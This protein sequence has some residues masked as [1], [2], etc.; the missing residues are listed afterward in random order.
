VTAD[1]NTKPKALMIEG[2]QLYAEALDAARRLSPETDPIPLVAMILTYA[3]AAAI[4]ASIRSSSPAAVIAIPTLR[5][6]G[7]TVDALTDLTILH[8]ELPI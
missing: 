5:L 1:P 7:T 4:A 6:L 3:L 2:A 8:L